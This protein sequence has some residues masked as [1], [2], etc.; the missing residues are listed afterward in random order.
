[1]DIDSKRK[2]SQLITAFENYA[3]SD[4]RNTQKYDMPIA[5]FILCVCFIDQISSFIYDQTIPGQKD[6]TSRSKKFI[7]EYL[8]KVSK[9]SYD[10]DD[11]IYLLR[12]KLV[13]NYSLKNPKSPKQV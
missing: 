12:N 7:A 8:N 6:S 5:S 10:K 2:I 4:I 9:K 13:H 1:M 3:L 11:L